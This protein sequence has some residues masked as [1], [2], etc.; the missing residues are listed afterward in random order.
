MTPEQLQAIAL[1]L[2]AIFLIV[3]VVAVIGGSR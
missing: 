3:L 2:G 1:P